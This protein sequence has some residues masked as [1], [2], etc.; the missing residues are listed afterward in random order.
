[1]SQFSVSLLGKKQREGKVNQECFLKS[2]I[3]G[4]RQTARHPATILFFLFFFSFLIVSE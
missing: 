2:D 4:L 1:M 3:N